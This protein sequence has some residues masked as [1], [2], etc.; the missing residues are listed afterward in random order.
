MPFE[1][2]KPVA[3]TA[4]EDVEVGLLQVS[5]HCHQLDGAISPTFTSIRMKGVLVGDTMLSGLLLQIGTVNI[6]NGVT[7]AA[8]TAMHSLSDGKKVA[9]TLTVPPA[10]LPHTGEIS[11]R[12]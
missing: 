12:Q 6:D 2:G 8:H 10:L 11:S 9:T 4:V 3:S 1:W 5:R 7:G